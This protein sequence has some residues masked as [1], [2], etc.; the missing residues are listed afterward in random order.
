M[1]GTET[2]PAGPPEGGLLRTS[3]AS[4]MESDTRCFLQH[5]RLADHSVGADPKD[6]SRSRRVR[7]RCSEGWMAT[8][9][10]HIVYK[11]SMGIGGGGVSEK[12]KQLYELISSTF[13]RWAQVFVRAHNYVSFPMPT[14]GNRPIINA[15][16]CRQHLAA[17]RRATNE[18]LGEPCWKFNEAS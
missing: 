7:E 10:K 3:A 2:A 4:A 8:I 5:A 14:T 17:W 6:S 1:H 18:S 13:R 15:F 16:A 11:K 12:V 9:K